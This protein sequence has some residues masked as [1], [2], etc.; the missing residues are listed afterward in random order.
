MRRVG[1]VGAPYRSLSLDSTP[2]FSK[3]LLI[4]AR[5][6]SVVLGSVV[7]AVGLFGFRFRHPLT[8]GRVVLVTKC[9]RQNFLGRVNDQRSFAVLLRETQGF[10]RNANV[11]CAQTEE[12]PHTQDHSRDLTVLVDENIADL[13]DRIV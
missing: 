1:S 3:S 13:A 4:A 8:C 10:E 9:A 7:R 11:L 2:A 5:V 6:F 12:A